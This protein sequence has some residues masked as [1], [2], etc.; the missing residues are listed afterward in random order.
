MGRSITYGC[1]SC[2]HTVTFSGPWE[3]YRD[4]KGRRKPYGHPVPVSREAE[5][6][7]ICGLSAQMYCPSC[8]RGVDIIVVEFTEPVVETLSV[9]SRAWRPKPAY[10]DWESK[11]A[12]RCPECG[13]D[14]VITQ[15]P[16]RDWKCP[17]CKAGAMVVV[18]RI[19]S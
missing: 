19:I 17:K 11:I 5:N 12:Y 18:Q 14:H 16:G 15:P 1:N 7:G 2:G 9:W 4:A 6:R 10:S 13:W 3:F 8:H